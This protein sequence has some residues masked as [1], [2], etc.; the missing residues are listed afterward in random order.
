M[1]H[2]HDGDH[3]SHDLGSNVVLGRDMTEPFEDSCDV[4]VV[5]S[6]AGGAVMAATLA[7]AGKRVIVVEEGAYY[8]PSD[9]QRFAPSESVRRMFREAGMLMA[10][11][12][13]QTPMISI[14]LGRAVS[15]SSLLTGGVCF[16]I[17]GESTNA[18]TAR[19]ASPTCQAQLR[20]LRVQRGSRCGGPRVDALESARRYVRAAG[21]WAINKRR[22]TAIQEKTAKGTH[23]A[24]S[25]ARRGPIAAWTEATCRAR[26]SMAPSCS[27]MRW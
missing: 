13:G 15:G 26:R 24:T 7:E 2:A 8:K 14:T 5:G 22:Y 21:N 27:P 6:G 9:Y 23:A 16:R 1:S 17:P 3:R 20:G 12:V 4:V 18:G 11:G 10:F 19:W 25:L